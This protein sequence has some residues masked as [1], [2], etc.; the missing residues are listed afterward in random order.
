MLFCE[1]VIVLIL[2]GNFPKSSVDQPNKAFEP[3]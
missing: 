1:N 3:I 2:F